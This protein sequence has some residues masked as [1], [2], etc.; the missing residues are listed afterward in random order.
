M[1]VLYLGTEHSVADKTQS[2]PETVE[3]Y[4]S[5]LEPVSTFVMAVK[6]KNHWKA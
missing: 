2:T 6:M 1:C 4:S 3:C 5:S